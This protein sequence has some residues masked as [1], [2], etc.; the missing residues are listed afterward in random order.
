[1]YIYTHALSTIRLKRKRSNVYSAFHQSGGFQFAKVK[2]MLNTEM[3]GFGK[4]LKKVGPS[5]AISALQSSQ[6]IFVV[7]K[8]KTTYKR[9][10]PA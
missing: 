5:N 7:K 4:Q 3:Q 6:D 2:L 10:Y 1:M 9:D 8:I